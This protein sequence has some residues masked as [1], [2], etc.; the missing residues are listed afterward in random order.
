[1]CGYDVGPVDM[2]TIVILVKHDDVCVESVNIYHLGDQ[3]QAGCN[4]TGLA[5]PLH[6]LCVIINAEP[7]RDTL[8]LTLSKL[9]RDGH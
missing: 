4:A 8:L 2:E 1:M 7:R 6:I 5:T 3:G 9:G